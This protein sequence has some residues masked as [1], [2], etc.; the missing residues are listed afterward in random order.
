MAFKPIALNEGRLSVPISIHAEVIALGSLMTLSLGIFLVFLGNAVGLSAA[1]LIDPLIGEGLRNGS[2]IYLAASSWV[3]FGFGAY[4]STRSL[5]IES[6][7]AALFHALCSWGLTCLLGV[8]IGALSSSAFRQIFI[9]LGIQ[10]LNWLLFCM[11]G[12]GCVLAALG[13]LLGQKKGS[14]AFSAAELLAPK[15]EGQKPAA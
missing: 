11:M 15:T 5:R 13:G 12:L 7:K 3:S 1:N 10:S 8:S 14:Q 4:F 9:G 6:K 2:W